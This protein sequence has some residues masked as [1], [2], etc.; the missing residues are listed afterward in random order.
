MQFK[1]ACVSSQAPRANSFRSSNCSARVKRVSSSR[2]LLLDERHRD[3]RR[4]IPRRSL[5]VTRQLG[6]LLHLLRAV[7]VLPRE[8]VL[9][10]L[11]LAGLLRVPLGPR[12]RSLRKTRTLS[13][14]AVRSSAGWK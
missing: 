13:P 11:L 12:A 9:V 6:R 4:L 8:H 10:G 14:S 7:L 1:D 3:R 5:P 2:P